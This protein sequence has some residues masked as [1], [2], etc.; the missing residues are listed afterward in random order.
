MEIYV[1]VKAGDGI[2]NILCQGIQ[3]DELVDG[4]IVLIGCNNFSLNVDDNTRF[5]AEHVSV[6]SGDIISYITGEMQ[7]TADNQASS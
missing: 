4:N 1:T 5:S 3:K 7:S 6:S 2:A